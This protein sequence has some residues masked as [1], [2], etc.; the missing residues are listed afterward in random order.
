MWV[1][2]V[3]S[4]SVKERSYFPEGKNMKENEIAGSVK[5]LLSPLVYAPLGPGSAGFI[6]LKYWSIQFF[7][8]FEMS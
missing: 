8:F 7:F 2:P 6:C 5:H 3:G 1:K 4:H